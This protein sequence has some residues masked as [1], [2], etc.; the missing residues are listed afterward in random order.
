MNAR[1]EVFVTITWFA[2]H[3]RVTRGQT[4][5]VITGDTGTHVCNNWVSEMT[6]E[7]RIVSSAKMADRLQKLSRWRPKYA[8]WRVDTK[9]LFVAEA[10]GNSRRRCL[11]VS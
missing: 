2:D 4:S 8:I 7:S 10:D 9:K 11:V 3:R 1:I 5:L 6:M